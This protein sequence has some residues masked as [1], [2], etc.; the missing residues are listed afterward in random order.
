MSES[1]LIYTL[2]PKV[3]AAVGSIGKNSRNEHFRFNYRSIDDVYAA[4]HKALIEHEV[5]VTPF[6]QSA[7]YDGT[8]CRLIVDYVLSATD[9][10]SI[11]SRIASE[12][13]DTADKATSKAL[14]MAFKY[15]A[16]QQF[17]IP[18][19]GSDDGDAGGL[20]PGGARKSAPR[21]ARRNGDS[22][23]KAVQELAKQLGPKWVPVAES[24]F[25]DKGKLKAGETLSTLDPDMAAES[26]KRFDDFIKALEK[27]AEEK[28]IMPS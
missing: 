26:V 14:S 3:A 9:G 19:E 28:S 22:D 23:G 25:A 13:Q 8:A 27:H 12:A 2:V 4:L 16:F 6:V 21:Q 18:V 1:H 20:V 17:C 15:W 7:E 11:T 10:S 24:F 5:T